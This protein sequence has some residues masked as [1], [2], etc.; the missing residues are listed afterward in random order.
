[1][2]TIPNGQKILTSS[3]TVNTTYGGPDSLKEMNTW[4]TMSDIKETVKP[5][6]SYSAVLT[7][8]STSAPT[9]SVLQ[10]ELSDAIVWTRTGT[11]V[12]VGTLTGAFVTG[13]TFTL[14]SNGTANQKIVNI[15]ITSANV[16][17]VTVKDTANTAADLAGTLN[18]EVRVYN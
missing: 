9:A 3:S 5:Y 4:Y 15:A 13:K 14:F 16:I 17:T 1:M 8:A 6:K 2:A 18:L 12:Y 7:Q 10:N 11:G